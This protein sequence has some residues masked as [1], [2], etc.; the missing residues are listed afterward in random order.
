MIEKGIIVACPQKYE[1][2]LLNNIKFLRNNGCNL[3]I[4]IWE[5]GNEISTNIRNKIKIFSNIYFRNVKTYTKNYNH[6]KGFQIKAFM[7]YHNRFQ[8]ILL[9][10]ADVIFYKNP[11]FIFNNANY[12]RT[13]TY[14]FHDLIYTWRFELR[15]DHIL[16]RIPIINKIYNPQDK[17]H[18]IKFFNQRKKFIKSLL[19]NKPKNFPKLWN[20]IYDQ[21]YPK[22]SVTETLQ[23]SGV[24]FMNRKKH[25]KSIEYIYNLNKDHNNTYKYVWGDKETFWLGV[26]LANNDYY[27]HKEIPKMING[28][29]THF[30]NNSEFWR[31]K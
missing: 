19:P 31:Q 10:D 7:L 18:S 5:I 8:H 26:L 29:V 9:M 11:E 23:E 30:D 24:V 20:Y 6:W 17:F 3:P 14:F 25:E 27:F 21:E 15:K 1:K 28:K 13:G 12:I 22:H 16:G 2:I 4:E